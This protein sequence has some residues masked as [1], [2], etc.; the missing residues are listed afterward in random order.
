MSIFSEDFAINLRQLQYFARVV[1]TGNITRAAEQLFVAQPALGLQIR[2]L[3]QA[4]GVT[5]LS[6]HSRGVSPTRAG[7]LLYERACE[8]LRLVEETGRE[9]SAAGRR[10]EEGIVLGLTN[11]FANIVGRDLVLQSRLEAPGVKLSIVEE[12]SGP[13][14]EALER[15]AVDIVLAYE[16]HERPGLLRVP[17][18]EE[19][20]LFVCAPQA[21]VRLAR[22]ARPAE[23]AAA[24]APRRTRTKTI[25]ETIEFSELA[26]HRLV[27]PGPRDGVRQQVLATAKRLAMKLDLT[28]DVSSVSMMKNMVAHGDAAAV[29]PY[30]NVIDDIRL[31]RIVG[32][33]IV[34]PPLSR[35][36]YLV[37]PSRRA[38]FKFEAEMLELVARV[39]L[40]YARTLGPLATRLDAL[41]Q[42]G[43]LA[44]ALQVLQ[45]RM[46]PDA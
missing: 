44:G 18:I 23:G 10:D 4:M 9:V 13:L 32:R 36:L 41:A 34:N 37:R 25:A 46:Q 16:V 35:T 26:R 38:P 7:Q 5:L 17:L 42:P 33:R 15:H 19:A 28:L 8:I 27:M 24:S 31:G 12:R 30:G 20:T 39:S 11:G 40:Q 45:E 2:Q 1:E 3:E 14:I 43:A 6:R 22:R 21:A 29:M